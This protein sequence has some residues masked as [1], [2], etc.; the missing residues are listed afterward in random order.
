MIYFIHNQ[1]S[2]SVKIGSAWNPKGRRSTLQIS[3]STE[4]VILGKIPGTK[5]VEK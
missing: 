2:R 5:K 4:L 3:N 1:V